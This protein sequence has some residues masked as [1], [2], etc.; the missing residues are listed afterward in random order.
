M[1]VRSR[2]PDVAVRICFLV[3]TAEC[4]VT[5]EAPLVV[6]MDEA[7]GHRYHDTGSGREVDEDEVDVQ[8]INA[9]RSTAAVVGLALRSP[10]QVAVVGSHEEIHPLARGGDR[11]AFEEECLAIHDRSSGRGDHS[12]VPLCH[13]ADR[14]T[15]MNK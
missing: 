15:D 3:R 7:R 5:D 11:N 8:W 1:I 6:T 14:D 9:V 13:R 12:W 4:N 2:N 10:D